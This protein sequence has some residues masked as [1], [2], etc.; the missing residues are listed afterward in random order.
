MAVA[1]ILIGVHPGKIFP[2]MQIRRGYVPNRPLVQV[3]L[4]PAKSWMKAHLIAHIADGT[5]LTS[6]PE[7][8]ADPLPP[9]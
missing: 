3:L 4:H 9:I 7:Q 2:E 6:E 8:F 5:V 1:V